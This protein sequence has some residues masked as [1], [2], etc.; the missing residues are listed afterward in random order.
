MRICK[1]QIFLHLAQSHRGIPDHKILDQLLGKQDVLLTVDR[2]LHNQ[3]RRLG[4]RSYTYV[5]PPDSL[6]L[7]TEVISGRDDVA[8]EPP[9][10]A[11]RILLRGLES[12]RFFPCA[13]GPFHDAMAQKLK[14][15]AQTRANEL[16]PVDFPPMCRQIVSGK[17]AKELRPLGPD[18]EPSHDEWIPF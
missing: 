5:I 3:A 16:V 18:D 12:A 11:L 13:K 17:P 9:L 7:G 2:A 15:L 8:L 1:K 10:G 14:R 4:F 6:A